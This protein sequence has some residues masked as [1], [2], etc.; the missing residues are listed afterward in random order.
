[1]VIELLIF[2]LCGD[3]ISSLTLID[4]K[5]GKMYKSQSQSYTGRWDRLGNICIYNGKP[6][7]ISLFVC[8]T[9]PLEIFHII[10]NIQV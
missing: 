1:M 10:E 2:I 6:V 3:A 8:L 5:D 9:D 7:S 4:L